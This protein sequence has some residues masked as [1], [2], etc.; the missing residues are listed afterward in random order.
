MLEAASCACFCW[1]GRCRGRTW[2]SF[3]SLAA[4]RSHLRKQRLEERRQ[5][6]QER[7]GSGPRQGN[8]R[9]TSGGSPASLAVRLGCAKIA[10][11]SL[12]AALC[13]AASSS[14]DHCKQLCLLLQTALVY[15]RK[16]LSPR[17][18]SSLP[19]CDPAC[20]LASAI[21]MAWLSSLHAALL[22]LQAA[23]SSPQAVFLPL[24]LCLRL[25][26]GPPTIGRRRWSSGDPRWRSSEDGLK[27]LRYSRQGVIAYEAPTLLVI[28]FTP[29]SIPRTK[30]A[31]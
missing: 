14:I 1:R 2:L 7:G 18:N 13:I 22:L 21:H 30:R 16:Q 24:Q 26:V 10:L 25:S 12:L 19:I 23:L 4:P 6:C 5:R 9:L 11:L 15:H 31:R 29:G 8:R 27:N 3:R 28:A 17:C 20:D